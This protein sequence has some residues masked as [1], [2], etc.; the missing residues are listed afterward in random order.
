M[1]KDKLKKENTLELIGCGICSREI[2]GPE[3]YCPFFGIW[4]LSMTCKTQQIMF[5]TIGGKETKVAKKVGGFA[6][7][8]GWSN[9]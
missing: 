8:Y 1:I 4:I 6:I 9:G 3:A 5:E 2:H 7:Q